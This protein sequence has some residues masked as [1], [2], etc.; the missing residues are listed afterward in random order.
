MCF[1]RVHFRRVYIS[2]AM[3]KRLFLIT[4]CPNFANISPCAKVWIFFATILAVV[5]SHTHFSYNCRLWRVPHVSCIMQNFNRRVSSLLLQSPSFSQQSTLL[6]EHDAILV[7]SEKYLSVSYYGRSVY[8]PPMDRIT[9]VEMQIFHNAGMTA[10]RTLTSKI[11]LI[12]DWS[13]T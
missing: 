4:F 12:S 10:K 13:Q 8:S 6:L 5:S 2:R 1:V 3:L 11:I 7:Y 9:R